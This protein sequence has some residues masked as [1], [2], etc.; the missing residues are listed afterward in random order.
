MIT[1]QNKAQFTT[2]GLM[3]KVWSHL[4]ISKILI[5]LIK[6]SNCVITL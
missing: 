1:F 4:Y 2:K 3:S 6:G 5:K